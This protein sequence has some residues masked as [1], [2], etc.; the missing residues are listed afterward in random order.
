MN[1]SIVCSTMLLYA[2]VVV[3]C[4]AVLDLIHDITIDIPADLTP[5]KSKSV[6]PTTSSTSTSQLH[7]HTHPWIYNDTQPI[8]IIRT[9]RAKQPKLTTS[10]QSSA[11]Q[12][13]HASINATQQLWFHIWYQSIWP[14]SV[15]ICMHMLTHT[16]YTY[17][18][19]IVTPSL[20]TTILQNIP[21]HYQHHSGCVHTRTSMH[22]ERWEH[23]YY[24]D[25]NDAI[26]AYVHV[27]AR[28]ALVVLTFHRT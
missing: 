20:R 25:V 27:Q 16:L 19:Y 2:V 12:I 6:T 17:H 13:L 9:G 15:F 3:V 14:L 8:Q 11:S 5:S 10:T 24:H 23:E 18:T 4:F 28:A 7:V 21:Q 26:D 22:E 1:M